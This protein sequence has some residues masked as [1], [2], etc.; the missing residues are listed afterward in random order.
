LKKVFNNKKIE[1]T[2]I[3]IKIGVFSETD[4]KVEYLEQGPLSDSILAAMATPVL[5][6]GKIINGEFYRAAFP[7]SS[8]PVS[9]A[10]TEQNSPVLAVN[11][12]KFLKNNFEV[13]EKK[14]RY[15]LE[16]SESLERSLDEL[17]KADLVI[18]PDLQ[19][20]DYFDYEKRKTAEFRGKQ[21]IDDII[22]KIK[23]LTSN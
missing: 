3:P 20:I 16:M 5:F 22:V 2:Y 18:Q 13:R 1:D 9:K 4:N 21:A 15:A 8:F 17:K 23:A 11:V 19:D 14:D 6:R 10:K 7:E 12:L